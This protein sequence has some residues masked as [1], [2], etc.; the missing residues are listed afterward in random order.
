MTALATAIN[1][2]FD[3]YELVIIIWCILSWFPRKPGGWVDDVS[4]VMNNLVQPYLG[5]FRRIIPP[6]G[7][8][9]WSPMIAILAL[10]I[11]QNVVI[12]LL[13]TL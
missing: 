9:D 7:G 2:L 13:L 10:G 12:R 4:Q 6:M 11:I 5:L 8:I 3:L 1:S